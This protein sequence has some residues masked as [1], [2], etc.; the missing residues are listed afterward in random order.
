LIPQ[1]T[2]RLSYAV[3]SNYLVCANF[4]L[5]ELGS[6]L[7][8]SKNGGHCILAN[9]DDKPQQ[10]VKR[11][12]SEWG[13]SIAK[14]SSFGTMHSKFVILFFNSFVRVSIHPCFYRVSPWK[15]GPGDVV[16]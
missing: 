9:N 5:E 14:V 15:Q 12:G 3:V 4:L 10:L 2:E 7:C 6:L 8:T 16:N 1:T 13:F 11:L